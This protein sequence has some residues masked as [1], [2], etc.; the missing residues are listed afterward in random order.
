MAPFSGKSE[1]VVLRT[2]DLR[3]RDLIVVLLTRGAGKIRGVAR[4]ARGGRL[5]RFGGVFL[6]ASVVQLDWFDNRRGELVRIDECTI[7]RSYFSDI[8]ASLDIS[9][10]HSYFLEL[11]DG[12][13]EAQD[14]NDD[15]YRLLRLCLEQACVEGVALVTVRRYFEFWL[16]RL[17][18]LF[19]EHDSCAGCGS[20]LERGSDVWLHPEEGFRC[21]KCRSDSPGGYRL[22]SGMVDRL[23]RYAGQGMEKVLAAHS[24]DTLKLDVRLEKPLVGCLRHHLGRDI[25]S[26]AAFSALNALDQSQS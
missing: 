14:A 8:S 16:L 1:A 12:F 7:V 9:L 2:F 22:D 11:T 6:P 23:R 18:G 13:T 4:G 24:P 5:R 26:L 17:S 15:L 3:E 21:R 25:R 10:L 20:E 19:P